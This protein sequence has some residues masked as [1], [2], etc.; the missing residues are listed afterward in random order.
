MS[1]VLDAVGGVFLIAGSLTVLLAAI[2]ATRFDDLYARMHAAAKAPALGVVFV[3]IGA[4]LTVRTTAVTVAA[5]L[6]VVLQLIAGPVGATMLGH[7]VYRAM[8]P[9]LT[10]PDELAEHERAERERAERERADDG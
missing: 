10:G 2:G 5:F 3:G 4:A 9:P 7:S 1:S 8:E 6:V